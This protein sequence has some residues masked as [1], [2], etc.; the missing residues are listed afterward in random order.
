MITADEARVLSQEVNCA[1]LLPDVSDCIRDAAQCGKRS[2]R[3]PSERLD[4]QAIQIVRDAGFTVRDVSG[5][6]A[7]WEISW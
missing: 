7:V 6:C 4:W 2:V 1:R 5:T 3:L